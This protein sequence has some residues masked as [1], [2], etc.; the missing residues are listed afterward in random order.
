MQR[1]RRRDSG[2]GSTL[3]T[4]PRPLIGRQRDLALARQW[5]V[6]GG[7]RL[8]TLTGPP[9]VGKTSLALALANQLLDHFAGGARFVE[10]A[11]I[12]DPEEVA[13][14]I[15]D[16]LGVRSSAQRRPSERL[17]EHLRYRQLLL[18]LDNFEQI[19]PAAPLV[20]DLLAVCPGSE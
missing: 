18:V 3:P 5:L 4:L 8:V 12:V 14:T 6:E 13:P 19:L 7:A 11:E 9:G 17:I 1:R 16:A 15:A 2:R 20:G 10:L